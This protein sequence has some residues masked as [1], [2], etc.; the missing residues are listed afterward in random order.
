VILIRS[1]RKDERG[2]AFERPAG[3]ETGGVVM[4][5]DHAATTPDVAARDSE[6]SSAV[7]L[8]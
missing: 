3:R 6:L 4:I 5:S 2:F 7:I 1:D 8:R